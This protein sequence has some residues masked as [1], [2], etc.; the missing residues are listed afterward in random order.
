MRLLLPTDFSDASEVVL[1]QAAANQWPSGSEAKILYVLDVGLRLAAWAEGVQDVEQ[2]MAE[3][4]KLADQAAERLSKAGLKT[5][6]EVVS[7]HPLAAVPDFARSWKADLVMVGSH[8]QSALAAFFWGS[9][10]K[11]TVHSAPCSVEI[12]RPMPESKGAATG[13]KIMLATDGSGYSTGAARSVSER[14]WPAGS[15]VR[16]ITVVEPV[17]VFTGPDYVPSETILR[18]EDNSV[19]LAKEAIED[20]AAIVSA[21][22][23]QTETALLQ[24]HPKAEILAEAQRWEA[25]LIVLG[26]HGRRGLDRVFLGSVAEA[27]AMHAHCSVLVVRQS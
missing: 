23:L 8:G 14:E 19:R 6:A 5:S 22:G 9:V 24:G 2:E 15:V 7:G 27:V 11:A 16:V 1:Q 12:V 3:A 18:M 10:A 26:S 17:Q 21:K 20:A 13:I 25:D 4:R